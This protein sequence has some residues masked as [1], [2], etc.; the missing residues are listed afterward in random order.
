MRSCQE[1]IKSL[2]ESSSH[3]AQQPHSTTETKHMDKDVDLTCTPTDI[4]DI[5]I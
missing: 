3:Q 5:Y 4:C 1:Q 2:L